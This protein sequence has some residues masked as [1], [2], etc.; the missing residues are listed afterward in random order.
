MLTKLAGG[1]KL[2]FHPFHQKSLLTQARWLK[3]KRVNWSR[4]V[5]THWQFLMIR[6]SNKRL[7]LLVA[8]IIIIPACW[9]PK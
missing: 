5:A 6:A 9:F 7:I 1:K 2:I 3:F 4:M 8:I